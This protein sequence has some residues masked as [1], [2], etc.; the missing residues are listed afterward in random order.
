M[1]VPVLVLDPIISSLPT[2]SYCF[3]ALTFRTHTTSYAGIVDRGRAQPGE[4]VLVHAAAGGVGLAAVQIAKGMLSSLPW[5]NVAPTYTPAIGCKVIGAAGSEEKR[6]IAKEKGG[7]DEVIDYNKD[8]W[9][10]SS[11]TFRLECSERSSA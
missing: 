10:V 11:D 8:G 3:H 6:R 7:A 1:S 2:S 9:Q 5:V 4:W